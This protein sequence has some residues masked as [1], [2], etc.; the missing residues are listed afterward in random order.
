MM[1]FSLDPVSA[2]RYFT[3]SGDGKTYL[4]IA[5]GESFPKRSLLQLLWFSTG[6]SGTDLKCIS[7]CV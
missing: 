2:E 6:A 4:K 7:V 1:C 3:T 5:P